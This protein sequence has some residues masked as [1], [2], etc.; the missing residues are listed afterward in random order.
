MGHMRKMRPH[1]NNQ[2]SED[3]Y[4]AAQ[5][6]TSGQASALYPPSNAKEHYAHALGH[7]AC[8][9][10]SGGTIGEAEHL[11]HDT[12]MVAQK[13]VRSWVGAGYCAAPL[14]LNLASRLCKRKTSE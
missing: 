14:M 1:S 13:L 12:G 11:A 2:A 4:L 9:E 10:V 7:R 8:A 5:R 3:T 6:G